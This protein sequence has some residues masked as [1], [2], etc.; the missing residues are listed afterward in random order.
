MSSTHAEPSIKGEESQ[1]CIYRYKTVGNCRITTRYVYSSELPKRLKY[2]IIKM[3]LLAIIATPLS[4][5]CTVPSF[6]FIRKVYKT[7]TRD[8][9]ACICYSIIHYLQLYVLTKSCP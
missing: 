6:Y 8:S 5:L 2:T 7:T 9:Q 4:L 3:I 1:F